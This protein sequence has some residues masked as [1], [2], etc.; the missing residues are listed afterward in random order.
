MDGECLLHN[1]D[2]GVGGERG[3]NAANELG[4]GR[5]VSESDFVEVCRDSAVGTGELELIL[6]GRS[7]EKGD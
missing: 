6:E 3:E 7:T 2:V 4:G 5:C 1:S